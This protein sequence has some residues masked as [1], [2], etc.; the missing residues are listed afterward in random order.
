MNINKDID[1]LYNY[2]S[3]CLF[4]DNFIDIKK[5]IKNENYDWKNYEKKFNYIYEILSDINIDEDNFIKYYYLFIFLYLNYSNY[6]AY[7]N[8]VDIK[9]KCFDKLIKKIKTSQNII[10]N[11]FRLS[12]NNNIKQIIKL[13]N[14]F[15]L[16]KIKINN[17]DEYIKNY[18]NDIKQLEKIS[19]LSNDNYKKILN[20]IIYRFISC[21]NNGYKNYHNF[22][23]TKII[24][25]FTDN[26][27]LLNF[28][29]FIKQIPKSRKI[30]N[31]TVTIPQK[32]IND[33]ININ[34]MNIL[35]FILN[36]KTKFYM[37]IVNENSIVIKNKKL[38]GT[39][40]INICD[41]YENIEFNHYQTN[42]NFIHYNLEQLKEFNFLKKSFS[43]IEINIKN[44]Y[45]TDLSS[46][47]EFVHLIII[48]LKILSTF[49]SDLYECL[50]PIDYTNY[51]YESFC[52][53]FELIK[54]DINVNLIYNK[55]IIDVIKFLY[56]YSYYDY[57]FYFSDNL[58]N[59]LVNNLEY[60]N[61][62]F[63]EFINNLKKNLKL[64]K[65]LLSFPP[66]F[67]AEF[68]INSIIYYNFE[69]P[70]YFKLFD[71][72]NAI[73][74]VFNEK[75]NNNYLIDI[76]IQYIYFD[77]SNT[78]INCLTKTIALNNNIYNNLSELESELELKTESELVNINKKENKLDLKS[79]LDS[80]IINNMS[81]E[82]IKQ[83]N[84]Q[85][86][87]IELNSNPNISDCILITEY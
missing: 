2:N 31:M 7:I 70:S 50:Y 71:F 76:I 30:L 85:N 52:V 37:N 3:I 48:S 23:I 54:N 47:L 12:L 53:F 24:E 57:Y 56:I 13:D 65:E 25:N 69:I 35:N 72:I 49:P 15:I 67:N 26:T 20:L 75:S 29:F 14:I 17:I 18:I 21:K 80:E 61:E 16:K 5:K 40:K 86:T 27:P 84:K 41:K 60:K 78:S 73:C 6:L 8:H 19:N 79:N 22:Y 44:K 87:Y 9:N 28:D 64:P 36:K 45:F 46:I 4:T 32:K 33:K 83:M 51:Y 62:I 81:K 77:D 10:K 59:I 39:I 1:I 55:F 38:K 74:F 34:I 58:I 68:D 82:E 63:I 66:F 11:I 42:Y 43:S